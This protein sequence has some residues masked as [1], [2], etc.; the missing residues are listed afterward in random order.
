MT[1]YHTPEEIRAILDCSEDMV[2]KLINSDELR[3]VDIGLGSRRRT[4]RI[5]DEE[6]QAFLER[7]STAKS[8]AKQPAKRERSSM[9]KPQ[10]EWV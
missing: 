7:R 8:T 6:F 4:L 1:K 10:K 9:P 2:L 5:S 3:A